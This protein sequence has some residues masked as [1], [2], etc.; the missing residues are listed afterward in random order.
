M[1]VSLRL[2]YK[3]LSQKKFKVLG[4]IIHIPREITAK[5]YSR[6]GYM[7]TLTFISPVK[8]LL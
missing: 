6:N 1:I 7:N 3:T 5:T 2:A 4:E 8:N